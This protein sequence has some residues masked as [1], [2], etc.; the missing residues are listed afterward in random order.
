MIAGYYLA[1]ELDHAQVPIILIVN[2]FHL[3]I[4]VLIQIRPFAHQKKVAKAGKMFN[5]WM[6]SA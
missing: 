1:M 4:L 3:A 6:I 2:S 5:V